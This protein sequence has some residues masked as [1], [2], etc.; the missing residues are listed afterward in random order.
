MRTVAMLMLALGM[1]CL[2][3]ES[4][5]TAFSAGAQIDVRLDP[6]LESAIERPFYIWAT[7]LMVPPGTDPSDPGLPV[8]AHEAAVVVNSGELSA[9]IQSLLQTIEARLPQL[10]VEYPGRDI[11]IFVRGR[12]T[13]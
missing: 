6:T 12:P 4:P 3:T 10:R 13:P 2:G 1:G 9:F 5:D 11:I 7:V 8:V